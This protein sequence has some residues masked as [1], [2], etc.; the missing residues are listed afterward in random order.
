MRLDMTKTIIA[1]YGRALQIAVVGVTLA[2]L[3]VSAS[4]AMA[5]S[6]DHLHLSDAATWAVSTSNT[7]LLKALLQAGVQINEPVEKEAGWTLLHFAASSG[8]ERVVRFLLDN[9]ADPS[10]RN[11]AGLRPIDLAYQHSRT[12]ICQALT[13]TRA[14]E[15]AIDGFPQGVLETVFRSEQNSPVLVSVNRKDPSAELLKWLRRS[16]PNAVPGSKGEL[17]TD[18][19]SGEKHYRNIETKGKMASCVVTIERLNEREYSWFTSFRSGSLSGWH[20][21]GKIRQEYGYWVMTETKSAEY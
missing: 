5:A 1:V 16:W 12:N 9:G 14:S 7:E 20:D 21:E 11:N 6:D 10:V 2:A 18:T 4:P 13:N 3:R 19:T 17:A 8:T 15:F